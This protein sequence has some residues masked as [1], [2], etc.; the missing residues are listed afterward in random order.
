MKRTGFKAK[1]T[2]GY[3]ILLILILALT[4]G[5]L[6]TLTLIR[7]QSTSEHIQGQMLAAINENEAQCLESILLLEQFIQS[8]SPARLNT[9]KSRDCLK[10]LNSVLAALNIQNS[11]TSEQEFTNLLAPLQRSL[12]T[13]KELETQLISSV[14]MKSSPNAASGRNDTLNELYAAMERAKDDYRAIR[15]YLV[16]QN[17][18]AV[19]YMGSLLWRMSMIIGNITWISIAVGIVLIIFISRSIVKPVNRAI[20]EMTLTSSHTMDASKHLAEAS[21]NISGNTNQNAASLEEVSAAIRE[22]SVTSQDTASNTQHASQMTRETM[23][24]AQKSE[25][26]ITRMN[27]VI[28]KIKSA[29]EETEKIMKTIDEIAFQTN[30][31]ALNA[32]VEAARAG[33][34]GRGFAVVAEEVRNLA[35]R[36]AEASKS[37]EVL[38][39]ESQQSAEQGVTVSQEVSDAIH[40]IIDSLGKVTVL[41]TNIA[42]IC[43]SQSTGIDEISNSVTHMEKATQSTAA[44]SE[45]LVASSSELASQ[46]SYLD[47]T[48]T[49]LKNIIGGSEAATKSNRKL[50]EPSSAKARIPEKA[51]SRKQ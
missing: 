51:H 5:A 34:A 39:R 21:N 26:T 50:I 25:Q 35:K 22:M 12:Q 1:L 2:I 16:V 43:E 30:L 8:P 15:E 48:I 24:A 36:S 19:E 11:Y 29:S 13:I 18:N 27:D 33:D 7:K 31:L 37:T 47:K 32:A 4:S 9:I 6:R 45:E 23:E 49:I 42:D 3:F 38:I 17:A 46:A 41:I 44:N 14:D 10:K 40:N 28:S 20:E